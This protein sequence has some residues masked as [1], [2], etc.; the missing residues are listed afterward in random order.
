MNESWSST[1]DPKRVHFSFQHLMKIPEK[2]RKKKDKTA[3]AVCVQGP[4]LLQHPP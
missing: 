2:E 3:T 4:P 1:D